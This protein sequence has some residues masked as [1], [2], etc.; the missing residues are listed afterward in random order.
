MKNLLK[1]II[2]IALALSFLQGVA[3]LFSDAEAATENYQAGSLEINLENY[4]NVG[5]LYPHTP[6][7]C[8]FLV[9]NTGTLPIKYEISL[10]FAG[11]LKNKVNV[12]TPTT[13][14]LNPGQ[15][16]TVTLELLLSQG[17]S[18]TLKG[19]SDLLEIT[20]S[21]TQLNAVGG[22][23]DEKTLDIP[24]TV[25]SPAPTFSILSPTTGATVSGNMLAQVEITDAFG[26]S[27]VY[28]TVDQDNQ[29]I[30]LEDKGSNIYQLVWDS[31]ALSNGPH[32]LYFVAYDALNQSASD[33]V[34]INVSN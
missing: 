5:E 32:T 26:I 19:E 2:I 23:R 21:A 29:Q 13:A 30:Q 6:E 34:Q 25:A 15:V 16:D 24:V 28:Y 4:S 10:A 18:P 27:G 8:S 12:T 22:F 9:E 33:L 7:N 1:S 14:T 3:T 11:T 17:F 31:T 20:V